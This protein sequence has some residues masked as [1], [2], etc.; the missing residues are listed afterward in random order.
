M[1]IQKV[2]TLLTTM[3]TIDFGSQ[4]VL[5]KH[6]LKDFVNAKQQEPEVQKEE[7]VILR[8]KMLKNTFF[9]IQLN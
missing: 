7:K 4:K 9:I 3:T 5:Q 1:L 2:L 8:T 6:F